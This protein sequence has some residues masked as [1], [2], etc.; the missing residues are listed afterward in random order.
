MTSDQFHL[1]S[2]DNSHS[3]VED[4]DH[5]NIAGSS[6]LSVVSL[7]REKHQEEGQVIVMLASATRST[8]FADKDTVID[9]GLEEAMACSLLTPIQ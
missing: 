3:G 7:S 8:H 4:V 1:L 6:A 5:H 9:T 2:L